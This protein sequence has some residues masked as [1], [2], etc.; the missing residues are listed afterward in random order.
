MK[1]KSK[2][3]YAVGGPVSSP[4]MAMGMPMGQRPLRP[5]EMPTS[6][7]TPPQ[8]PL[9]PPAFSGRLDPITDKP[10]GSPQIIMPPPQPRPSDFRVGPLQFGGAGTQTPQIEPRLRQ[11][12]LGQ[13]VKP[14]AGFLGN[15]GIPSKESILARYQERKMRGKAP[16]KAMP[17]PVANRMTPSPRPNITQPLAFNKG[18]KIDG[19]AMRGMT[20]GMKK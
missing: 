8:R 4:S 11:Q 19:C 5:N 7:P 1:K 9:T 14:P 10:V 15:R 18:G 3:K 16:Q 17:S 20:K 12:P 6:L 13:S 2:S